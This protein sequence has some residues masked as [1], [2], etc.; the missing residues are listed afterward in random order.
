MAEVYIF[1]SNFIYILTTAN[2]YLWVIKR[3][4]HKSV[5]RTW[6]KSGEVLLFVRG[7]QSS[8][9]GFSFPCKFNFK[10]SALEAAHLTSNASL[11]PFSVLHCA[12]R[13]RHGN[14]YVS[15]KAASIKEDD[16]SKAPSQIHT[17]HITTF[18]T[19]IGIFEKKC[20]PRTWGEST[21]CSIPGN[22]MWPP[23]TQISSLACL[24]WGWR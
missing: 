16:F 11:F 3:C 14:W 22:W 18:A 20:W 4:C 13:E 12:G 9:N 5:Q 24:G 15:F 1:F 17:C 21:S 2:P 19:N 6:G 10:S 8:S 7:R 23:R